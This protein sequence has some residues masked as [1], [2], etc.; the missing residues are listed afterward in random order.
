MF[1]GQASAGDYR[2]PFL[3]KVPLLNIPPTV[4]D[5][6]AANSVK[7]LDVLPTIPAPEFANWQPHHVIEISSPSHSPRLTETEL[8]YLNAVVQHPGKPSSAYAKLSGVSGKTAATVRIRLVKGGFL[9]EHSVATGGRG[10]T[11][12]VLE[13][14]SSAFT[15]INNSAKGVAQ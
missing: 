6:A 7:A 10:R 15:V 2:E 3:F 13:P 1:V 9:R 4:D 14:L 5:L 12:I 8:R 11:A